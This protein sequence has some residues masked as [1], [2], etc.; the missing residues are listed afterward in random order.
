MTSR[1]YNSP[2]TANPLCERM[3]KQ[4]RGRVGSAVRT[5]T[6]TETS[7]LLNRVRQGLDPYENVPDPAKKTVSEVRRP[8]VRESERM[9]R[10]AEMRRG[11]SVGSSAPKAA[12][13]QGAQMS[14]N[15]RPAQTQA[16]PRQS[17][18]TESHVR[19]AE[20]QNTGV[21][22]SAWNSWRESRKAL[23]RSRSVLKSGEMVVRA[24]FPVT[25]VFMLI[26]LTLMALV[27]LLSFSQNY[28]LQGQIS[29]LHDDAYRL[30]QL[31]RSLE[32]QLE[33]R[34]DIRVIERIAVEELG[35]VKYDLVESRF[36]SVSGGDR[37]EL[38]EE[39]AQAVEA[40]LWSTMLSAVGQSFSRI[41][42]YIE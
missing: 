38:T 28:E 15:Q 3:Q 37:I 6:R 4:F 20:A 9:T 17:V 1:T 36:V 2:Q 22:R 34:D 18:R 11:Q 23:A 40:G 7:E 13:P 25:G 39:D 31:Q 42:E 16:R 41:R 26:L 14:H 19:A 24:P 30:E 27:L 29:D 21:L 33:E 35:M 5:G 32:I 10:E 12:R 8:T